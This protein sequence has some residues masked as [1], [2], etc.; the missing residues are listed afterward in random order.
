MNLYREKQEMTANLADRDMMKLLLIMANG[1]RLV[2]E[3]LFKVLLTNN[4]AKIIKRSYIVGVTG[5]KVAKIW[6]L[7]GEDVEAFD[8]ILVT[9][10]KE[11]FLDIDVCWR[12][13]TDDMYENALKN[14]V[15][16]KTV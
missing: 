14:D 8:K 4:G 3:V 1:N 12:D 7:A 6:E 13:K 10:E 15:K 9:F 16:K 2:W 11:L 5:E